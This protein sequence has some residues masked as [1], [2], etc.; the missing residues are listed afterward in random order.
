MGDFFPLSRKGVKLYKSF[1]SKGLLHCFTVGY[2]VHG[3][4]ISAAPGAL[5]PAQS[6]KSLILSKVLASLADKKKEV[7]FI[8]LITIR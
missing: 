1:L 6:L 7:R 4:F 2:L 3:N 8:P 5:K